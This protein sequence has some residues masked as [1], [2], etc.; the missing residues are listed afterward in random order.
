VAG[1]CEHGNE[2]LGSI[3]FWEVLD[4]LFLKKGLIS[5]MLVVFK[6]L[7]YLKP[8]LNDYEF[9]TRRHIPEYSIPHNTA[10]R[11]GASPNI[12]ILFHVHGH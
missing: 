2:H 4:W 1:C 12:T 5:M 8:R 3:K 10:V 7:L 11:I 9:R 6:F